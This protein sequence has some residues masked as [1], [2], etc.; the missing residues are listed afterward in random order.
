[1]KVPALYKTITILSIIGILLALFLYYEYLFQPVFRPC[2]V[3]ATVN[4]DAVIS[5]PIKTFLGIP[6]S[7]IGLFGYVVI[8]FAALFKKNSIVLGMVIFGM[9]FCIRLIFIEVFVIHVV[10]PV[11]V[12]CFIVMT[13]ILILALRLVSAEKKQKTIK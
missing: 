5:G 3:N 12:S 7:L 1:M 6:V 11:C 8:F 13:A 9:L 4:C 2:S 10:C